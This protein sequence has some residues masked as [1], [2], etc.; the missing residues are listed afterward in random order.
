MLLLTLARPTKDWKL[1]LP[2]PVI[3]FLMNPQVA[4]LQV[5]RT[6]LW[7]PWLWEQKVDSLTVA[8]LL[9]SPKVGGQVWCPLLLFTHSLATDAW[10][11]KPDIHQESWS[12][13]A[14]WFHHPKLPPCDNEKYRVKPRIWLGFFPLSQV[15]EML[16]MNMQTVQQTLK[17]KN[18]YPY[19]SIMFSTGFSFALVLD[20]K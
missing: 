17:K 16:F 18:A 14:I 19:P 9:P 7:N 6:S 8:E 15:F 1:I 2:T 3:L 10:N 20:Q 4:I 12:T 5:K 13:W 11:I